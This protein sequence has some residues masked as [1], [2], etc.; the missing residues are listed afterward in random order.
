MLE[1]D[2]CIECL[3]WV[4]HSHRRRQLPEIA[5]EL[6]EAFQI[7]WCDLDETRGGDSKLTDESQLLCLLDC[8]GNDLFI[9][10]EQC[11]MVAQ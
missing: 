7:D 8:G 9:L 3:H 2:E 6:L 4:S 10:L 5:L 1:R 11:W